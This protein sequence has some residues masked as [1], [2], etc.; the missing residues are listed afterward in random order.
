MLVS[1]EW[2]KKYVDFDITPEE[3]ADKLTHVG[4]EVESVIHLERGFP[5]S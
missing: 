4:L 2:L 3:L 1:I 5:A